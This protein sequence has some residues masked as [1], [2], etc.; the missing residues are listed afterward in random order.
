MM[1][2]VQFRSVFQI[3]LLLELATVLA[4]SVATMLPNANSPVCRD[5]PDTLLSC[6]QQLSNL[7]ANMVPRPDTSRFRHNL[8][9]RCTGRNRYSTYGLHNTSLCPWT[10]ATDLD[11]NRFPH[12][13]V[14]A[15][16]SCGRC[17][18]YNG[19]QHLCRPLYQATHVIR[20]VCENGVYRY[21]STYESL[22]VACVCSYREAH[23]VD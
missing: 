3:S 13:M 12:Q 5:V 22:P 14:Y 16:C 4:I 19:V 18:S 23:L 15:R 1:S 21:K 2:H 9:A 10:Y 8:I 17:S 7:S 11:Y 6:M 20:R